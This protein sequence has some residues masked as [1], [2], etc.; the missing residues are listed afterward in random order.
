MKVRAVHLEVV[1]MILALAMINC[2]QR[3]LAAHLGI[4]DI[5]SDNGTN[6]VGA[7]KE[8]GKEIKVFNS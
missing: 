3:F 1:P 8:I 7:N 5:Y 6:F 4:K 2:L